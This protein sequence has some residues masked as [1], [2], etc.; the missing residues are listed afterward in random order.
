[1]KISAIVFLP[2]FLLLGHAVKAQ[3][4]V[5]S[6]FFANRSY[7]NPA[8]TGLEDGLQISASARNQWFA[9]DRG[10]SFVTT[11]AEWQEPLWNSGFGIA[12]CPCSR[13]SGTPEIL[14]GRFDV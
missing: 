10:Y 3:D 8:F 7:L 2:I 9:A 5:L 1:M 14:L 6:Q 13:R 12:S 11:T 4:P